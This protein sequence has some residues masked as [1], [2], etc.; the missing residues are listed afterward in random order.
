VTLSAAQTEDELFVT[1]E[2]RLPQLEVVAAGRSGSERGYEVLGADRPG[3]PELIALDPLA[4]ERPAYVKVQVV[5]VVALVAAGALYTTWLDPFGSS[6]GNASRV[7]LGVWGVRA[8][9]LGS[10]PPHATAVDAVLALAILLVLG[11]LA[12]RAVHDLRTRAGQWARS[13]GLPARDTRAPPA[14]AAGA[15]P[16][17]PALGRGARR[18]GPRRPLGSPAPPR[19]AP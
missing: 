7:A 8:L 16:T 3:H 18:A 2:A 11:S 1:L 5:L 15:V 6:L 17:P 13:A 9:M 4:L 14:G 12:V 10:L 19:A